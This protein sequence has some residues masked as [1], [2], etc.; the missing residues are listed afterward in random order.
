MAIEISENF[1]K[2]SIL[3]KR[4]DYSSPRVYFLTVCSCNRV[5]YFGNIVDGIMISF[6][7]C[8]IVQKIWTRLP[9]IFTFVDLDAFIIMPNHIH[10]II[11]LNNEDRDLLHREIIRF[12]K[13]KSAKTIQDNCFQNFDWQ[14]SYYEYVVRSTEELNAVRHYIINNPIRWALDRENHL[15]RNFN[16]DLKEYHRDIL[17]K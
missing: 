13:A 1:K 17:K 5:S 16:K 15:S 6:P 14:H 10:G 4:Y 8:E 11:V 3:F 9:E 7:T 2:S 12:F